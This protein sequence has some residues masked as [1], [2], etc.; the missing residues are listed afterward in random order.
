MVDKI[1]SIENLVDYFIKTL[2][3]RVFVGHKGSIGFR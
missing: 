1:P 3:R 2:T